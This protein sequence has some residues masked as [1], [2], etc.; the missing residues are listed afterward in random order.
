[1]LGKRFLK[2]GVNDVKIIA[3]EAGDYHLG[4]GY[5][6]LKCGLSMLLVEALDGD[7]VHAWRGYRV[8]YMIRRDPKTPLQRCLPR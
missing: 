7:L 4:K 5:T 6:Y 1:M 2:N 3:E 8:S